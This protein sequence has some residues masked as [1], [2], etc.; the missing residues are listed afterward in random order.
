MSLIEKI[1]EDLKAALKAR[2]EG[3]L[4]TIRMLK[5]D[6]TYKHK[7]LGR[8]L[9]DEEAIAVFGSAAKKRTEAMDEFRRGGREDLVEE[10]RAEYEIIKGFLPEQLSA[11]DLDK[12]IDGAIEESGASSIQDLGAVMKILMPKIR[13]R[14]DGKAVNTA[15]REKLI[16]K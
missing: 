12:A 4:K 10:E 2:D 14:A 5:S 9:T 11:H 13:G 16:R 7:E 15:V 1:N 8:E 3:R 6:L